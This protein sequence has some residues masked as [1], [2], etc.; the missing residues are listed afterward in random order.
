MTPIGSAPEWVRDGIDA[1]ESW[2]AE[3]SALG[4][5]AVIAVVGALYWI[6]WT[7][8]ASYRLGH[9]E[10]EPLNHDAPDGSEP[11]VNALTSLLRERLGLSGLV[12]PGAVPAGSPQTAVI[13]AFE[14]SGHPQ[15]PW[16]AALLRA[17]PHPP[18]PVQFEVQ[19]T[20]LGKK[21]NCGFRYWV[22]PEHGGRTILKTVKGRAS[23]EE[24]V[25]HAAGE[26]FLGISGDAVNVFPQ[27][28]R[29]RDRHVLLDYLEGV[30]KRLAGR[31]G[32][33]QAAFERAVR[34]D[35][36]NLLPRLQVANLKEKKAASEASP[37]SQAKSQALALRDYLDIGVACP[38]LVPARYRASVLAG[39]L[40]SLCELPEIGIED[41]AEVAEILGLTP[42]RAIAEL[43]ELA[44]TESRSASQLLGRFHVLFDKRR[45]RH[46]YE[47][48]GLERRELQRTVAIS[49][50]VLKLRAL[51]DDAS[52]GWIR[53]LRFRIRV[54]QL[55]VFRLSAGWSAHYNAGC[56][57]ALL[58]AREVGRADEEALGT[59]RRIAYG[60]LGTAID[61]S[62]GELSLAWLERDPD[63]EDVRDP[64][65][66]DWQLLLLR[67]TGQQD[68]DDRR[69]PE[70]ARGDP[71]RRKGQWRVWAGA[72]GLVAAGMAAL[73]LAVGWSPLVIVAIVATGIAFVVSVVQARRLSADARQADQQADLAR[74]MTK[75]AAEARRRAKGR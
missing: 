3:L 57:Y 52:Q 17:L 5:I 15:A 71:H 35:P 1:T 13:S 31:D 65:D 37:S 10:V 62:G 53:W 49:R 30:E 34:N 64:N 48:T 21:G 28:S 16:V 68:I 36:R 24:A 44:T 47:P 18:R 4:F 67:A 63:L 25:R 29:W 59:L 69:L 7:L 74:E 61:R 11:P 22:R 58:H 43:R 60:E 32:E 20:L 40:A 41:A 42:G 45:L 9:L 2:F 8:R 19:G 38:S 26:I 55:G 51:A 6:W 14:A 50:L 12:P 46:R 27:W 23:Y 39:M 66:P 56:F 54:E 73:G 75:R 33:A 72:W 70:P